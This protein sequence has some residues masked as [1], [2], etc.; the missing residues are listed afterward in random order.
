MIDER[1]VSNAV[2]ISL[3]AIVVII[4]GVIAS[5]AFLSFVDT[6]NPAP[7]IGSSEATLYTNDS[8]GNVHKLEYKMNHGD[9]FYFSDKLLL[10]QS[11][12]GRLE[13]SQLPYRNGDVSES[14]VKVDTDSWNVTGNDVATGQIKNTRMKKGTSFTI[15][16]KSNNPQADFA[17]GGEVCFVVRKQNALFGCTVLEISD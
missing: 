13:L 15:K 16:V 10:V 1:G 3:L 7:I 17:E 12:S 11:D 4:L 14:S 5:A 6:Q 9:N 2:A 8:G